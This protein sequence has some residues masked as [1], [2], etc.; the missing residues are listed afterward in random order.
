ME[1]K[2]DFAHRSGAWSIREVESYTLSK[3]QPPPKLGDPQNVEKTI[4]QKLDF[5]GCQKSVF[6][7]FWILEELESLGRQNQFPREILFQI[8]L[9]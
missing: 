1:K 3:F 4:R 6:R 7:N 8:H 5:W 2:I 9:F